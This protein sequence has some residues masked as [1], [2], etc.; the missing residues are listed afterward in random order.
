M[1]FRSRAN[2]TNYQLFSYRIE[3]NAKM[4]SVK[5]CL[6]RLTHKKN[7]VPFLMSLPVQGTLNFSCGTVLHKVNRENLN[8]ADLQVASD[9]RHTL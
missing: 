1:G 4:N 2:E 6:L 5:A 9:L 7:R 8:I 3:E